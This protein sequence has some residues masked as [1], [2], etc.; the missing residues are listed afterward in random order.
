MHASSLKLLIHALFNMFVKHKPTFYMGT[1]PN[2]SSHLKR[3][4]EVITTECIPAITDGMNCSG[5]ERKLT[6][7]PP[8]LGGMGIPIASDIADREYEFS[9]M[10]SNDLTSKII[11]QERQHEPNN[12]SM[13]IKSKIKLLK[14]QHHKKN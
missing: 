3:L 11:N 8:K 7:L 9:Q 2:I 4:D 5:I 13:V 6:S 10:L 14:L 12:N 1:I